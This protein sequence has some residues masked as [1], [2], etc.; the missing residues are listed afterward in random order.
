MKILRYIMVCFLIIYNYVFTFLLKFVETN[1]NEFWYLTF[2]VIFQLT[3]IAVLGLIVIRIA[4]CSY[5]YIFKNQK[6]FILEILIYVF[7]LIPL[8]KSYS[9]IILSI[10]VLIMATVIL[11]KLSR[12]DIESFSGTKN[13]KIVLNLL[14]FFAL[15]VITTLSFR[16]A[17]IYTVF[18]RNLHN[19]YMIL[20]LKFLKLFIPIVLS[21][22][23]DYFLIKV[24]FEN[25]ENV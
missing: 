15:L 19:E 20:T 13:I 16:K 24:F 23:I 25:Q 9:Y 1:L 18:Y 22:I 7:F 4:M 3:F 12:F 5:H 2:A 14:T 17:F 21:F 6:E 11:L 10:I 8:Y